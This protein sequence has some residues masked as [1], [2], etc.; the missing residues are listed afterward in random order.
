MIQ[1]VREM[2]FDLHGKRVFVAG[3]R[4]MVGSALV[5][6][7]ASENC[8]IQTIG[9]EI[10]DLRDQAAVFRWFD[11]H[12][13]EAVFVAA[14]RVGGIYA[15]DTRP[16]DFLYDNLAIETNVI[17]A[18]RRVRGTKATFSRLIVHLS[19]LGRPADSRKRTLERSTRVDEPVVRNRQ[20]RRAQ[21]V[22]GLSAAT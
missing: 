8:Q 5:R 7:L 14:A 19:A 15:N 12:R 18:A 4:G 22:R 16:G 20:D 21:T 11:E 9:R 3:H 17:E 10:V 2:N 13:P 6:R 1:A